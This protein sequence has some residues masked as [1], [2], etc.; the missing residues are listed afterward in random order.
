MLQRATLL[1]IAIVGLGAGAAP[2]QLVPVR[3]RDYLFLT[4]VSDARALWVNPAGLAIVPE[5]SL[6]AELTFERISGDPIRVGQYAVGFN[7]RGFSL[8]YQ[9]NRLA[10]EKS[11]GI[12]RTGFGVPFRGGALGIA[13]SR[14]SQDTTSSYELDVGIVF[15]PSVL[16]QM[17]LAVR[18]IGRPEVRSSQLPVT[19]VGGVQLT[20]S[21][22]QVSLETRAAERLAP[23]ESGFDFAHRAGVRVAVANR[24]PV[25]AIGTTSAATCTSTGFT[26]ASPSGVP[27]ALPPSARPYRGTMRR[28]S[29]SSARHSWPPTR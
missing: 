14:V 20:T 27:G 6:L 3:S 4:N 22:L 23:G 10:D 9:R 17:G 2:A 5:A 21:L 8:G 7:S 13:T 11:V 16:L 25:M 24:L 19:T 26:S 29:S 15:V 1:L 12:L 28:S 18:H